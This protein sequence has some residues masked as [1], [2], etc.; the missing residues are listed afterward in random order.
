M[1]NIF[2]AGGYKK[3]DI[4]CL[5]RCE[6]SGGAMK[7]LSSYEIENA[8][9]IS[10]APNKKYLYAVIET[11]KFNGKPGGGV[12]A[13]AIEENGELR[14]INNAPTE[15]AHP[16]HL[17][18][19]EDGRA[20][21][22]A[23]YSGGSSIFFELL[24][25]VGIGRKTV[26]VDHNIFGKPSGVVANR[27]KHPHAHYIKPIKINGTETL[28]VCDLGLDAVLLLDKKGR[29][30]ARVNMPG[31]F[32]PRHIDFH[33]SL[34]VAYV[35]GELGQ[36]VVA[37][38]FFAAVSGEVILRAPINVS[39]EANVSCAAIRVS[40]CGR[41]LLVS[42]RGS[43]ADSISILQLENDGEISRL[44]NIFKTRGKCPRDFVF[45][46]KGD[47][48]FVAY[49]DSD[50]IEI[51]SWRDGVLTTTGKELYIQKPTCVL[52]T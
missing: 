15:G 20:L 51:L 31:G 43:N 23:N 27:Q 47:E 2:Y 42:N 35:V 24:D 18:V 38:N 25:E 13:F 45:S 48:V 22:V 46:P 50:F 8:S 34:P 14:F 44:V 11:D 40:P 52:F 4:F 32:G 30:I 29:E 3:A 19:S 36:G 16:C 39:P 1:K 7:V 41:Y 5:H 17:S 26:F 21:Y 10:I 12:A 28:W 37:V 9:Y 33:P 49:Q 6:Y